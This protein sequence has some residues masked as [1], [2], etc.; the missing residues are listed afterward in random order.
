MFDKL[1]EQ[2]QTAVDVREVA[3]DGNNYLTR[4][5]HLPPEEPSASTLMMQTLTG[6][7]DYLK[8]EPESGMPLYLQIISPTRVEI[9]SPVA[10]RH[11][12]RHKFAIA[13]CG[14]IFK[15]FQFGSFLSSE[16]FIINLQSQFVATDGRA[17]VLR[18]VGNVK[19]ESV[20]TVG[21]DGVTQQVT[22]KV[23]VARVE[24]VEVPNPVVLKP[25]RTFPEIEQPDGQFVLRLRSSR[26]L[27]EAALF[28]ADGGSW[29]L[30]AISSIKT[31][32][33]ERLEDVEG[34]TILA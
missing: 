27:P 4:P 7:V 31:Y 8:G 19:D 28:E 22:A 32:L 1:I 15:P 16:N 5:L 34:L 3:I 17:V 10:G 6:L 21:D 13:D 9:V 24:N 29:K 12:N 25:F 26:D 33:S 11:L 30:D 14:S 20:K 2:L 18:V 23:G